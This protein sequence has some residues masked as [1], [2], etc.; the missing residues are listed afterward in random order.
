MMVRLLPYV[1][2][3]FANPV[4]TARLDDIVAL[5]DAELFYDNIRAEAEAR[6]IPRVV[7]GGKIRSPIADVENVVAVTSTR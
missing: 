3:T 1:Q 2:H 6:T 4:F 5:K 7:K